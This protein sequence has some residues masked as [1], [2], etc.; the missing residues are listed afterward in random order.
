MAGAFMLLSLLGRQPDT[1]ERTGDPTEY[2]RHQRE[3]ARTRG[4]QRGLRDQGGFC[5]T[6]QRLQVCTGH[7]GQSQEMHSS[8]YI[9]VMGKGEADVLVENR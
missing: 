1:E 2:E 9:A 6:R 3:Q 7:A 5:Q 4:G 8:G